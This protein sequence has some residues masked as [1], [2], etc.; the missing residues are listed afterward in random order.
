[1]LSGHQERTSSRQLETPDLGPP[2]FFSGSVR[3]GP[4]GPV[5]AKVSV[6]QLLDVA[7]ATPS[8]SRG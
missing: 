5:S 6:G 7:A 2:V 1:M 3:E 8:F 4:A